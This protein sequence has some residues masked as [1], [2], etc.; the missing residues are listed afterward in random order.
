[1]KDTMME[2]K[3]LVE[4][5]RELTKMEMAAMK[6]LMQNY[7][8]KEVC[9]K[10]KIGRTSLWRITRDDHFKA[11]LRSNQETVFNAALAVLV[12]ETRSMA[13]VLVGIALDETET[14]SNRI[15]AVKLAYQSVL[16]M[17]SQ[18]EFRERLAALER[19]LVDM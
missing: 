1:M 2:T 16:N 9:T 3:K 15:Q 19:R 10:L 5:K 8:L 18:F 7:S 17:G 12:G 4:G 6:L 13:S 11:E 14:T